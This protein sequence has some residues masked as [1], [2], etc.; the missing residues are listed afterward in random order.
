MGNRKTRLIVVRH[1]QSESNKAKF[2]A[3]AINVNLTEYGR[4]QAEKTAAFLREYPIDRAY[5][6]PMVRVIQTAKPIIRGRNLELE[7]I[8]DLREI[9]GGAW[10]GLSYEE[11]EREYPVE[12][13]L[14]YHNFI[15]CICPGGDSVSDLYNRVRPAFENIVADNYGKTVLVASHATPIRLML[16]RFMGKPIRESNNVPWPENASVTVVDCYEDGTY[17]LILSAY[18]EHLK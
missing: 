18:D 10:E 1:A 11:I 12:R 14:W 17:D 5:S 9:Y 2:Y 3:A 16:T 8:P 13:D 6:S 4:M 7:I 15:Y